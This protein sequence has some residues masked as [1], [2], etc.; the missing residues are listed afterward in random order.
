MAFKNILFD[1]DNTLVNSDL[2]YESALEAIGLSSDDKDFKKARRQVKERL[3]KGHVVARNRLFY[4][5]RLLE[6]RGEFSSL[7]VLR[8]V[9]I[10]ERALS[11][12]IQIQ[13]KRLKR[14]ALFAKLKKKKINLA[15]LT[16]E[17]LR[18]QLIKLN[19]IDPQSKYFSYMLT[20]E[21]IGFEKPDLRAYQEVLRV[22]GFKSNETLMVG[23]DVEADMNGG[24]AAGLTTVFASEFIKVP[25][26]KPKSAKYMIHK[27]DDLLELV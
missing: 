6:E 22:T 11:D 1:L 24:K 13:V 25:L 3:P 14:S 27:L 26:V 20:S 7:E 21:E 17:N 19:A 9:A 2:A 18:T 16:N 8:L 23:D 12:E 4:F 5:K 10:Y 15:I